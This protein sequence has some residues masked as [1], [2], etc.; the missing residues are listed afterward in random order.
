M[1]CCCLWDFKRGRWAA[2]GWASPAGRETRLA[3]H[4]NARMPHCDPVCMQFV[5]ASVLHRVRLNRWPITVAGLRVRPNLNSLQTKLSVSYSPVQLQGEMTSFPSSSYP[6]HAP[7]QLQ[8][9]YPMSRATLEAST[10]KWRL[11]SAFRVKLQ[12]DPTRLLMSNQRF[13][14]RKLNSLND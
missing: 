3:V 13:N 2:R 8:S 11:R 7:R 9:S 6:R 5:W 4:A 1:A 14:N 10:V 12:C